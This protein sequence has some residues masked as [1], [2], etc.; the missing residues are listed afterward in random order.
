MFYLFKLKSLFKK[1]PALTDLK[2]C[3]DL[4]FITEEE[5]LR[6]E[7]ERADK[8]LKDFLEKYKKKHR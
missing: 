3:V 1:K 2:K 8:R 6:L 7:L 5:K 4:G